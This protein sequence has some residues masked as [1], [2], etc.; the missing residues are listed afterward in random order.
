MQKLFFTTHTEKDGRE[1]H[2][3]VETGNHYD[4]SIKWGLIWNV[5]IVSWRG[6]FI[7]RCRFIIFLSES[8]N[9]ANLGGLNLRP[10]LS[11]KQALAEDP[12]DEECRPWRKKISFF[13]PLSIIMA[14]KFSWVS[15]FKISLLI[16][17]IGSIVFACFTLPVEKV[18][19]YLLLYLF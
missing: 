13:S 7:R 16:L 19:N 11:L 2:H 8:I 4:L 6:F 17:L 12:E 3:C 5:F 15:S 18:Y 9:L 10:R 1:K 14:F